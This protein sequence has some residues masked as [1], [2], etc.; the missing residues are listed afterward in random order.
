MSEVIGDEQLHANDIL[1]EVEP[2]DHFYA[3]T[4]NSPVWIDDT[5]KRTPRLAPTIGQHTREVLG[6]IGL[7]TEQVQQMLNDGIARQD[8]GT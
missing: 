6:E 1:T 3:Y 7:S 5:E 2:G 8:D 4:V